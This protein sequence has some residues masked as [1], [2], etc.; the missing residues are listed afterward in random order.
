MGF[1]GNAGAGIGVAPVKKVE[2]GEDRLNLDFGS[3]HCDCGCREGNV[4]GSM[5]GGTTMK[6]FTKMI[7][8]EW[9]G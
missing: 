7:V 1:V 4:L 6:N 2:G 3:G 9:E 5:D 8:L